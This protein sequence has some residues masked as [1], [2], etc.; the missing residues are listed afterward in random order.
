MSTHKEL[1]IWKL[2]INLVT[3]IYQCTSN[4]PKYEQ[5]GIAS[6]IQRSAVSIPSNIAEGVARSSI[7]EY[8]RFVSIALGSAAELETLLI[9]A[10]N[11]S[12]LNSNEIL[13]ELSI[14]Q[15][16]IVAFRKYLQSK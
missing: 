5:F 7:K 9:I 15:S 13:K 3:K 2:S 6:Q 1:D 12:Y 4:F 16:K 11:I 10:Q 8:R 14:I